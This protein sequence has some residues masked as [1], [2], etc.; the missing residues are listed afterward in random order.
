[1]VVRVG[2]RITQAVVSYLKT[3]GKENLIDGYNWEYN[4]IEDK[5]ANAWCMLVERL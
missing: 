4:L 2:R 5:A 1:M 3:I